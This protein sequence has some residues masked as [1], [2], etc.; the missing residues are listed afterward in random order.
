MYS[1]FYVDDIEYYLG[2]GQVLNIQND[3]NI[4]IGLLRPTKPGHGQE[5][6]DTLM[7]Q[8]RGD[9]AK[10]IIKPGLISKV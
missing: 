10:I 4:Q 2:D 8:D 6:Y 9:L 3:G 7:K 1:L 5:L